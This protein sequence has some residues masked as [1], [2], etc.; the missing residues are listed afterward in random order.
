[1][2]NPI[3]RIRPEKTGIRAPLGELE[4]SVM[5]RLWD[6]GPAGCL[7]VDVQRWIEDAEGRSAAITTVLTTLERLR[8]KGIVRRE[9]DGRAHRFF[10]A[11]SEADLTQRIVTGILNNLVH[12]Y[13]QAVATYFAQ[14]EGAGVSL[15]T[16]ALHDLAAQVR[17][18]QESANET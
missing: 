1:M 17:A 6:G 7:A 3:R 9:A 13:P 10:P 2:L 14:Q 11:I 15:E 18:A 12:Q 16:Q 8:T 5:R 4:K